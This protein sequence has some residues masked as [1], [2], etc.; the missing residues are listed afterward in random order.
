ML[1][2]N[3]FKDSP[4]QQEWR[5]FLHVVREKGKHTAAPPEFDPVRHNVLVSELKVLY[6]A[7]TRAQRR[8]WIV[9]ENIAEGEDKLAILQYW[10]AGGMQD[11]FPLVDFCKTQEML[12]ALFS[13]SSNDTADDWARQGECLWLTSCF[14]ERLFW[15]QS[16]CIGV[17]E[18][19]WGT[20]GEY[21]MENEH[22]DQAE[23]CF[24]R[25]GAGYEE[26]CLKARAFRLMGD[27]SGLSRSDKKEEQQRAIEL[28]VE[29]AETFLKLVPTM[30]ERSLA[31]QCFADAGKAKRAG[32]VLADLAGRRTKDGGDGSQ[33]WLKAAEHY[34]HA[35]EWSLAS[36]AFERAGQLQT[37]LQCLKEGKLFT[38]ARRFLKDH[39]D[40]LEADTVIAGEL[41][42]EDALV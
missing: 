29:A 39:E 3:F 18:G 5:L 25:A 16:A 8:L 6:T 20:S 24:G 41:I 11:D 12:E 33:L 36:T 15:M 27:A 38:D 13:M 42:T 14:V 21:L 22:Y 34:K 2:L 31:A 32:D 28:F 19:R 26:K 40:A 23:Y 7:I 37:A 30:L 9:D 10:Q 4:V 1:L 17:S 35:T